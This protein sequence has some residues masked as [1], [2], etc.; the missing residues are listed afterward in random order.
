MLTVYGI[1]SCEIV[2]RALCRLDD[3]ELEYVFV[4]L[5]AR[6]PPI[7]RVATWASHFTVKALRNTS[8]ESY[9]ALPPEKLGW[10]DAQWVAAFTLD[11]TLMRRPIL[12]VDGWPVLIGF[13]GTDEEFDRLRS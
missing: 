5:S 1:P 12:E 8:S 4:D 9:R 7:A 10:S 11:P 2:Q 13:R 3:L 6:R